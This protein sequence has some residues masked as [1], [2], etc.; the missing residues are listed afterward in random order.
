MMN[1][2]IF[3]NKRILKNCK[4]KV[5]TNPLSDSMELTLSYKRYTDVIV[6]NTYLFYMRNYHYHYHSLS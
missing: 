5:P 4:L 3:M 6:H 1:K 2:N